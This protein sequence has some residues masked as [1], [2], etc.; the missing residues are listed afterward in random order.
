MALK[1]HI[2]VVSFARDFE[3]FTYFVRSYEKFCTG[4]FTGITVVVPHHDVPQFK[5][6]CYAH[7]VTLRWN[8]QM[9]G[10]E[11]LSHEVVK[12]EADLWLP[13]DTD[14]IFHFDSDCFFHKTF[15]ADTWIFDGRP[16]I[17][18]ERYSD[19]KW[20]AHRYGWKACVDHALGGDHE[21][22]TMTQHPFIYWRRLYKDLREH[23]EERHGMPF[24]QYV[25]FQKNSFPQSFAEF[26]TL[27]AFALDTD[28]NP[29]SYQEIIEIYHAG[30]DWAGPGWEKFGIRPNVFTQEMLDN[31]MRH[32]RQGFSSK[33]LWISRNG[34]IISYEDKGI[35]N[36]V[37]THWSH[38][39]VAAHRQKLEDI[40][41]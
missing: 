38:G 17:T 31:T 24:N 30:P 34:P 27:G 29:S 16:R 39:G 15:S 22:E 4:G 14:L 20:Y 3:F 13:R 23:I 18:K 6:F 40:L 41:K 32:G 26:P 7:G 35:Y 25:L 2:L 11:F 5:P 36:P 19:F 8:L 33:A 9:P 10:K 12:C 1:C 37:T 21:W 28:G